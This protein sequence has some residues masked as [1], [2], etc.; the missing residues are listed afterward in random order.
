MQVH[1]FPLRADA[2]ENERHSS[3]SG[4]R[5]PVESLCLRPDAG[6][7]CA[8]TAKHG[9]VSIFNIEFHIFTLREGAL[10]ISF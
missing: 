8:I 2:F 1:S 9:D 3:G 7:D 6:D 4:V 10:A 5:L